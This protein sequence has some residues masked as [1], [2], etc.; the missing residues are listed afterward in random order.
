MTKPTRYRPSNFLEVDDLVGGRKVVMVGADGITAWDDV[1]DVDATTP[2]LT[3]HAIFR[4]VDLGSL[5]E[6]VTKHGL[7]DVLRTL[8][9]Q[10]DERGRDDS[11]FVMRVLVAYTKM[12]DKSLELAIQLAKEE[13]QRA[14]DMHK[15]L[16]QV[17]DAMERDSGRGADNG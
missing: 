1:V 10:L 3:T 14:H 12:E 13:Q 8:G 11:L 9:S 4:P 6:F 16:G 17:H 15:S 7:L 2:L 5:M